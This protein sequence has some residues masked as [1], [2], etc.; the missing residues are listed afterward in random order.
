M[1]AATASERVFADV[2]G[3][4]SEDY[5]TFSHLRA[6]VVDSRT[7][8]QVVKDGKGVMAEAFTLVSEC[9]R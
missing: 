4:K 2:T 5:Y 8:R 1:R 7:G 3:K 9:F 6:P